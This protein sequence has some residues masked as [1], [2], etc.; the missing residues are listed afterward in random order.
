MRTIYK[1]Q[2]HHDGSGCCELTLQLPLGAKILSAALQRRCLCLWAEVDDSVTLGDRTF[3]VLGTGCTMPS[4]ECRFIG[5]VVD[6]PFIWHVY[7][8]LGE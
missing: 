3:Y 8:R 6:E 5:T 4:I 1:Y 2:L 7:E